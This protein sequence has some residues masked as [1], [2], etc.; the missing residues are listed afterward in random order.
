MNFT[1][2]IK[3]YVETIAANP[4]ANIMDLA[5]AVLG[6]NIFSQQ[7]RTLVIPEL[8]E[9]Y[10]NKR[11]VVA[12]IIKAKTN[13]NVVV[14]SGLIGDSPLIIVKAPGEKPIMGNITLGTITENKEN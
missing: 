1:E 10:P 7:E 8:K 2:L 5:G 3:K 12:E 14:D 13:C 6:E 11:R 9:L 4:G